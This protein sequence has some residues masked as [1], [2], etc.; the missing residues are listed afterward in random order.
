MHA[1]I[2]KLENTPGSLADLAE[3]LGQQGINITGA[4][5]IGWDAT[6]A[7]ALIT[8][9]EA[10]TRALLD[11]RGTEYREAELVS[12]GIEDRQPGSLGAAARR[13]AEKGIN[14]EAMMATGMSGSQVTVAFA[15]DDASAAR[16]ALGD[17]AAVGNRPV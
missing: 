14:V 2:V 10:G 11:Q 16:E 9:D 7:V 1:F 8:A 3:A 5:G 6:G 13:L 12:A 4:T 17:L 15:V